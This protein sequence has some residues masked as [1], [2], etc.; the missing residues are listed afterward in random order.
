VRKLLFV[1]LVA[2]LAALALPANAGSRT[3]GSGG[4]VN[5]N[6]SQGHTVGTVTWSPTTL[7]P[8]NH[9]DQTI[10]INFTGDNDKDTAMVSV[11]GWS[12]NET[13]GGVEMNG[14]GQPDQATPDVVPGAPGS[15]PDTAP[16]QT[17]AA[18]RAERSGQGSGRIY[19]LTVTC[20]ESD[21]TMGTVPITVS[22]PHDQGKH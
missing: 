15:G 11:T 22:V 1:P 17:T 4:P 5:C 14:S 19:T 8:P 12:D 20:S 6:D 7:W 13:V 21:G 9:K 10:T 16:V 3:G 2:A 18:V